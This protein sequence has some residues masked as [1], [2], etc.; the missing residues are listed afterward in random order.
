MQQRPSA[1]PVRGRRVRVTTSSGR[2]V[3]S[4]ASGKKRKNRSKWK[5]TSKTVRKGNSKGNT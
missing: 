4:R 1:V 5:V 3:T 2:A